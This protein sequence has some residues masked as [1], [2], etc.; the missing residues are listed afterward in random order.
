M[1]NEA[2]EIV[3]ELTKAGFVAYFAGGCVRDIL[4]HKEPDDIDIATNA[5]PEEIEKLF[6]DT[7]DVGKKFGVVLVK[8]GKNYFDVATFREEGPYLDK[9]R[10]DWIKFSSEEEDAKRRDFT[11]NGMFLDP[12]KNK[13]IDYVNGQEDLKRGIIRFIGNPEERI[14]EDNLRLV[15]AIR[16]KIT[17]NFQYA[18][19]TFETI[20]KFSKLIKNVSPER[21]RNEINKI[22]TSP[23]RH[24]GLTELVQS[25][26]TDFVIPEINTLKGVPQP[27]EYHH[28][29]DVFTHTYLALKSMPSNAPLHLVWAVLLH[30][31]GKPQTLIREGER[32]IFHD[33]AKVSADISKNILIR[34]KFS[35]IEIRSICYLVENHMKIAQIDKMRPNK[36]LSFLLNPL[37]EDLI[38]LVRADAKGTYPVN[39]DFIKK[40]EQSVE[41]AKKQKTKISAKTE[42]LKIFTG[43]N[44]KE[45]GYNP[46]REF[47]TILENVRDKILSGE[48]S[49]TEQAKKYV[50]ENYKQ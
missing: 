17:L 31:I 46:S 50:L 43:D 26:I 24:I 35:R 11:I 9:R 12:I 2:R 32:I 47:K 4:L 6:D 38:E 1:V 36:Q 21:I 3:E 28:E 20:S 19:Q 40:L 23:R 49:S 14:E 13:V 41:L 10:P 39:L 5:K 22:L 37:F 7:I 25:K 42:L 33:H 27:I 30:D 45:L 34:L 44:L 15:R 16:F 48:I 8:S 29:G 18:N